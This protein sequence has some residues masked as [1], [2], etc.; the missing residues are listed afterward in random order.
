MST[1]G[2]D[3]TGL[4]KY[5]YSMGN[6][7]HYEQIEISG[8]AG[9]R[10][11]GDSIED[12]FRNAATGMFE[13][14]TNV[15][16]IRETAQRELRLQSGDC[17]SLLIMWLN[18]LIYLFET[19][20]FIMKGCDLRIDETRDGDDSGSRLFS[21]KARLSGG[22]FKQGMHESGLLIKAATYHGFSLEE[23]DGRWEATVIFDI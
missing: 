21:L 19:E 8:D 7:R 10:I 4:M 18:E 1:Q 5:H 16:G 6:E 2:V 3:T 22:T 11:W 20:D 13:L 23:S 9:L 14:I 17:G 12:I 15:S